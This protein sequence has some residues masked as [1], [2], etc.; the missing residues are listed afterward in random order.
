[1]TQQRNDR[2]QLK[3]CSSFI[4]ALCPNIIKNN[5]PRVVPIISR[6]LYLKKKYISPRTIVIFLY[7]RKSQ[8]DK[9]EM[10]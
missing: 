6:R 5:D 10:D 1:M 4:F 9:T 2:V 7:K 8:E 3:W